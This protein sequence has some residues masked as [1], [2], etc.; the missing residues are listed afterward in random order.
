MT[1]SDSDDVQT[2]SSGSEDNKEREKVATGTERRKRKYLNLHHTDADH[3]VLTV[4][5]LAQV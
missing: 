4:F 3:M 2:I 5:V 1:L